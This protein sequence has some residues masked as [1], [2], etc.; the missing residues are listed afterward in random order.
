MDET[1]VTV[2]ASDPETL[3]VTDPVTEP[4]TE[5][6]TV[7]TSAET[8]PVTEPVTSATE[9]LGTI[10]TTTETEYVPL[11]DYYSDP[12]PEPIFTEPVPSE[13]ITII[14]YTPVIVD[15]GNNICGC[16]LFGCMAVCGVLCAI[17]LWGVHSS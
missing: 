4:I 10:D 3:P 15:T 12:V 8:L 7:E 17:R 9:D 13:T 5:P 14:D 1:L 6:V 11:E 2:P 16:I